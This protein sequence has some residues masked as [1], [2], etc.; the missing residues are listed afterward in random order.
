[1]TGSYHGQYYQGWWGRADKAAGMSVYEIY[2]DKLWTKLKDGEYLYQA[3]METALE[4]PYTATQDARTYGRG[5]ILSS[6]I[7]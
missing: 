3:L 5:D 1:M 2:L 7:E 6:R 4:A